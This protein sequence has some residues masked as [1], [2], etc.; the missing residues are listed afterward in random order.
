MPSDFLADCNPEKLGSLVGDKSASVVFDNSKIKRFVPGYCA[1]TPFSEG[2]RR[3]IAWFDADP[4]RQVIDHD[5]NARW[6]K[7]IA[8]WERATGEVVKEMRG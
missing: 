1:T 3:T 6:D 7:L 4:A 5:A 2:I 8:A